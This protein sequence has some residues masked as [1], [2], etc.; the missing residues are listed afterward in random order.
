MFKNLFIFAFTQ[1]LKHTQD[2]LEAAL[3][4][5]LYHPC[6]STE[7]S[8]FGW[9]SSLSNDSKA[10]VHQGGGNL[11]ICARREEKILPA[12]VIKDNVNKRVEI[13]EAEQ[14]R[15]ATKK[16]KEQFKEDAIFE[17]LPRAFSKITDTRAYISPEN[18]I[19][20]IDSS[21]RSKAEDLIALLRKSLG[22]FPITSLSPE[23][24]PDE[25]MTDW[26]NEPCLGDMFQL[27]SE[28]VLTSLGDDFSVIKAKNQDLTLDEIHNHL[29]AEK[30]VTKISLEWDD[31]ISFLLSDDLS[32]KKLKFFDIILNQN[33][34]IDSDDKLARL[35]ADFIL[36]SGEINRM[37]SNLHREFAVNATDCLTD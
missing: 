15:S 6:S 23:K 8:H 24:S 9:T 3:Q 37:I 11:L 26:L 34:D 33:D 19:I 30:Y 16:E 22:S 31:S 14:S 4:E 21:S 17:L 5:L 32:I 27:G 1:E 2:Q 18:N 12:Q 25:T 35:D 7:L 10:L 29:D 36:M 13:L 28:V 20:V